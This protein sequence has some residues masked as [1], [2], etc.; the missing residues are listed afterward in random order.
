V[1]EF[2][3]DLTKISIPNSVTE[4]GAD[5]FFGCRN[6]IKVN[7][8]D[9]LTFINVE[10]FDGCDSLTDIIIPNSVNRI[11][12]G[13][14]VGCG[15]TEINIPNSVTEIGHSAFLGCG[16]TEINIPDSVT[17]LSTMQLF[18]DCRK[19][20]SITLSPNIFF[21]IPSEVDESPVH[22]TKFDS[23]DRSNVHIYVPSQVLNLYISDTN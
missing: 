8:P 15:L 14:F 22:Y 5:A 20:S 6:L 7:I 12:H 10:L 9:N 11:G 13:A 4:I 18:Q 23:G 21:T 16:L 17:S 2:C 19:L 1:F 3:E